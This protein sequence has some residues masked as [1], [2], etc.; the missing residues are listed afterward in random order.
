MAPG[1]CLSWQQ[2]ADFY[3]KSLSLSKFILREKKRNWAQKKFT[4]KLNFIY[5]IYIFQESYAREHD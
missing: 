1:I 5:H 4:Y 2:E 3:I